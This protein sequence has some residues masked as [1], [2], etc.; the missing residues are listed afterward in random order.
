MAIFTGLPLVV[1]GWALRWGGKFRKIT[2][3]RR[4]GHAMAHHSTPPCDPKLRRGR[5][6]W[7]VM[8]FA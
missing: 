1:V 6:A 7:A 2:P 4:E 5:L 8:L 3:F